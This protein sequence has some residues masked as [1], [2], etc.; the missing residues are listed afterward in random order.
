MV[1]HPLL[2][3]LWAAWQRLVLAWATFWVT[4]AVALNSLFRKVR[5]SHDNGC[6]LR[7][8]LRVVD[9]LT[10]PPNDFFRPGREF[11]V[12]VRHGAASYHDDAM[13]VVRS[14]SLKLS[15]SRGR[16]PLDLMLNTG[17]WPLFWNARTFMQFMVRSILGRGKQ[18]VPF[19]RRHPLARHGGG[20]SVRRN[21]AVSDELVYHSQTTSGFIG[22]DQQLHYVRYRLRPQPFQPPESG[23]PDDWER[24]HAWL[25]N[26]LPHETRNRNYLKQAIAARLAPPG[27]PL[28]FQLQ[29]QLRR[30]PP[31]ERPQPEWVAASVAWDEGLFPWQDVATLTLDEMLSHRESVLTWFDIGHHPAC[32]PIPKARSIDDAHSL[33]HLRLASIWA[34]RARRLAIALSGVPRAFPD[35]RREPDWQ[36]IP[37]MADPP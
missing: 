10:L 19:L 20:D 27:R 13:L 9:P 1:D 18:Y 4:L 11:I 33:N 26:P 14:A 22:H 37:P 32:L 6:L 24:L 8:R 23:L 3:K 2:D 30:P 17:R 12:R 31:V 16:S 28:V 35:S 29:M 21:P 15:D 34:V 7:G 36:G 25:Q 5:M